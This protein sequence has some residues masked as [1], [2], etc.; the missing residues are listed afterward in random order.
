MDARVHAVLQ[1]ASA[2]LHTV[3]GGRVD[4]C[5]LGGASRRPHGRN[6]CKKEECKLAFPHSSIFQGP[7]PSLPAFPS[8]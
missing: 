2:R 5:R 1:A 3:F 6:G 7:L 8:C 4:E